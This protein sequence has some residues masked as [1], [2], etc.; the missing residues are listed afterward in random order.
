M[1][2][3]VTLFWFRR[4]LRLNDNRSL[5]AALRSGNPVVP[6][7]IFDPMILRRLPADDRRVPFIYGA[8]EAL[9]QLFVAAGTS[10]EVLHATPAAAFSEL[11]RKYTIAE[12]HAGRDYEPYARERDEA[13]R[14]QL[15]SQGIPFFL[16]QDQVLLEPGA[17]LKNDGT[18]YTVYTPFYRKWRATL[19]AE[20]FAFSGSEELQSYF[21]RKS[22]EAWPSL[23]EMGFSA[24]PVPLITPWPESTL[25]R[26][27]ADTRNLPAVAGTSR[28]GVHLRFG[29]ISIRKLAL[30]ADRESEVFLK[31]LAWR[32]FF[33]H[34]LAHFPRLA[35]EA[36]KKDYDSIAWRDDLEGF[37][38][39]CKGTTGYP[40]VDAGM[41]ELT[42]TGFM[43][44][45]VRMV[46]ASF[47][48]KHLLIDWR[49]G[50]RW[51]AEQLMD[52]ELASNN[53]NWQWVA[54]CGCDAAPYFRIFN[55]VMQQQKFDPVFAYVRR[56]VPEYGTAAYPKPVVDHK[57]ATARCLAAY[58]RALGREQLS[59]F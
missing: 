16:H 5:A 45:R 26:Q 36:F 52:F 24:A 30:L 15:E 47:L 58:K 28:L 29:T 39:W 38:R 54:G 8:L 48:C 32:E 56:W 27:Y 13:I 33:M 10:L 19:T 11:S 17:V 46:T 9:Q 1:S 18:P 3:P 57:M 31:E 20:H 41:R 6:V 51:F 50:E 42:A 7:F 49:L 40:I 53:G 22:P 21:Y 43:H 37:D 2:V 35:G 14:T 55:P 44:N 4:D 23:G 25:I 12:V 59:L 34:L